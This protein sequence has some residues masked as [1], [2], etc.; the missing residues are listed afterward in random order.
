MII[1]QSLLQATITKSHKYSIV[2]SRFLGSVLTA[3]QRKDMTLDILHYN[4]RLIYV[5]LSFLICLVIENL[6]RLMALKRERKGIE[7]IGFATLAIAENSF[8][9]EVTWSSIPII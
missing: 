7:G 4:I 9:I 2:I 5:L 8:R 1:L 6:G 3:H